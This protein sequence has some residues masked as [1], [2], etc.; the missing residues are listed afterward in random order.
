MNGTSHEEACAQVTDS[1]Q[2]MGETAAR[3]IMGRTVADLLEPDAMTAL[4]NDECAWLKRY[5]I[6]HG[7]S[8]NDAMIAH[9]IYR[10]AIIKE[11]KR[12]AIGLGTQVGHA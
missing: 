9:D 7:T 8:E 12:I 2:R 10:A 3:R 11:G 6:D 4:V 1:L 5:F